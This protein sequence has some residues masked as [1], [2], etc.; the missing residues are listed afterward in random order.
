MLSLLVGIV[1]YAM[2]F[3]LVTFCY[4]HFLSRRKNSNRK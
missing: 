2:T 1:V 4:R 3:A